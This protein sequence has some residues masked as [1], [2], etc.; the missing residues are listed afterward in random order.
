MDGGW[1]SSSG[2]GGFG[3]IASA[4]GGTP[5][6]SVGPTGGKVSRLY[7]AV[8]GDTRP[9]EPDDTGDYPT[10][11]IG[12]IF[13]DLAHLSPRPEFVISTG[14]YMFAQPGNGQ[15]A[16]QAALYMQS[17][18]DFPGQLFP[19]L[20]NHECTG[21]TDSNCG[22]GNDGVTENYQAFL[23]TILGG[24]GLDETNT[25]TLAGNEAYY[26]FEVDGSDPTNPW[27][28]K[29]VFVAANAWD[30]GQADWLAQVLGKGT[31][32]TFVVRHEPD[33]DNDQC[34]G[35]GASDTIIKKYPY[36]LLFAGHDHTYNWVPGSSELVV[37]IGGA[38]IASGLYGYVAC[39]QRNDE[40]IVCEQF[41]WQSNLPS[42]ENA[43]VVVTPTG[44]PAQ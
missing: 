41:D 42:Y 25:S 12:T 28:A 13:G 18:Q 2:G 32:Y 35:C 5:T 30:D 33:Y 39:A 8:I 27:T 20:G 11:V 23:T 9:A 19:A 34:V 17:A 26:S 16:P 10:N 14:D 44:Q 22:S 15:A 24:A 31:D 6:G 7:F 36:T 1:G 29:F 37:G 38:Q 21:Y 4:L 40:D 3:T 43:Q